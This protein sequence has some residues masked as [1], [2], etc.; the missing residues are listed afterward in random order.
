MLRIVPSETSEK[1]ALTLDLDALVREGARRMLLVALRAE[2]DEYLAQHADERDNAGRALV[3]RNGIAEPRK[4]TTAAG[5]L[6]IQTPRV[7]DRRDGHRFTSA[8]LPPWGT[9]FTQG[10]RGLAHAVPARHLDQG[11]RAGAGGVFWQRIWLERI[12]DPATDA[13]VDSGTGRVP[14]AR[15]QSRRLRVPVGRW[16]P[17]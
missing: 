16:R 1:D 13:R 3:V 4:V 8:I 9:P 12:H 6:E 5:E 11:L 17:L 15:S 10:D 7:Y 2:V 14:P